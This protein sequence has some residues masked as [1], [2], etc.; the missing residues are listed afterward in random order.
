MKT[1]SYSFFS[2]TL[3]MAI[4]LLPA[5]CKKNKNAGGTTPPP[6]INYNVPPSAIQENW[7]G[8]SQ[9]VSR[10]F[11]DSTL[12]V[13]F[14]NDVDRS[15]TWPNS[16]LN[17]VWQYSRRTYGSGFGPDARLYAVFHTGR[18]SGGHPGYYYSDVHGNRNI[19]DCGSL[20]PDAWTAGTANDLDIVTHEIG[21]IVESAANG[22][23]GSPAFPIWK[24]SKWME[25][26]IYD[27]YKGLG[28]TAD[29]NR[30]YN[31]MQ[32]TVDNFPQPNTQWFKNWFYPIYTQYG[33]SAVLNRFFKLVATHFPKNA[34][35]QFTRDMNWGE[36]V[37]FWSGA[38]GV[39]LKSL[40]TGAFGWPADWE[41][42]FTNAKAEFP[43]IT[44]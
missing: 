4:A 38:A 18:Y 29:V 34:N 23:K 10:I 31:L 21:H 3:I 5:G 6:V 19:I 26:Y 43:A 33:G 17:Q 32:G 12:V 44:Y 9:Q 27:V 14:D 13:Y 16:F 22:T 11:Y 37:H 25:I 30:W 28:R 2:A 15:I 1:R 24:D 8:H 41:I 40:A 35:K 39:N 42:L 20:S 7:L 36:F